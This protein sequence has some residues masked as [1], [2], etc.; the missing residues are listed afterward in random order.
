LAEAVIA[1]LECLHAHLSLRRL[2]RWSRWV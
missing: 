2:P 1:S